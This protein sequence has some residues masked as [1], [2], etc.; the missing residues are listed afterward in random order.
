MW[1][2][3]FHPLWVLVIVEKV[4]RARIDGDTLCPYFETLVPRCG[5][6]MNMG[7]QLA[8]STGTCGAWRSSTV[9]VTSSGV[10]SYSRCCREPSWISMVERTRSRWR[11]SSE[12][13]GIRALLETTEF[14]QSGGP[15]DARTVHLGYYAMVVV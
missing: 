15:R 2:A 1:L 6:A 11:S 10:T 4:A 12:V 9:E 3:V 7:G 8:G 14:H 5:R 13:S